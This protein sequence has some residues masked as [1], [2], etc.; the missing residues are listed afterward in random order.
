MSR[1]HDLL[2]EVRSSVAPSDTTLDSARKHR[3]AVLASAESF[4]GALRTYYSGSIGSR[5]R[6]RRHRRGLRGGARPANA[7]R[8]RA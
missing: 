6:Q 8:A 5:H 4:D 2:D 7:D 1:I 3:E